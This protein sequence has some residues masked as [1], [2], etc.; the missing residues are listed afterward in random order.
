[1]AGKDYYQVLGVARDASQDDIKKAFRKLA[2]KYH[3]D[4]N[5]D[6]KEAETKFKEVNEAYAVLSDPDKRKQY[7]M[8]G[9]EGFG[10]RYSREDIF[11]NFDFSSLFEEMGLGGG[12]GG[13]RRGFD[14]SSLFGGGGGGG[15]GRRGFNPF[16]QQ[17]RPQKGR[18]IET[19]VT[20]TFHEAY[21]GGERSLEVAGPD[22][23]ETIAVRIPRGIRTGQTLRVREK[24]Q[25]G[26]GGGPRGDLL[27]K[28]NVADHP[29]FRVVGDDVETDVTVALT[30]VVLGGSVSVDAPDGEQHQ[31]KVPAGTNPGIRVRLKGMGMPKRDGSF[32]DLFARIGVSVPRQL[33][34]AQRAHFEALRESGV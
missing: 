27:L 19:E 15:G 7:D 25:P 32:G 9:A 34:D 3:P 28:V 23:A 33:S 5:P 1:M 18:D 11:Q 6:D 21:H 29:R 4:R 16:Q 24:G 13:G 8:F 2:M 12:G 20:I 26:A 30:D 31:V 14:F 17:A 22:G 10:Q